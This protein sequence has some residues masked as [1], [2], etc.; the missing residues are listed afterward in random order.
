MIP[1]VLGSGTQPAMSVLGRLDRLGGRAGIGR[2][3]ALTVNLSAN[4]HQASLIAIFHKPESNSLR[5]PWFNP[6]PSTLEGQQPFPG[7]YT[8]SLEDRSS[9]Q[10]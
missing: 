2:A 10:Q 9:A 7:Y 1:I 6:S 4:P 5:S 3:I 8:H